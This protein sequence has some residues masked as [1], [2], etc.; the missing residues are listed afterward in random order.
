M[1]TYINK[2]RLQ[3][4]IVFDNANKL[5]TV[6]LRSGQSIERSESV[7]FIEDG[8]K[9]REATKRS[10]TKKTEKDEEGKE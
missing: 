9:V 3:K 1:K 4:R 6:F 2:T 10:A 5:E 7:K 8:I